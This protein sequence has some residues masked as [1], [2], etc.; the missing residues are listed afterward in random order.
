MDP[1]S[2]TLYNK[3]DLKI[4][5]LNNDHLWGAIHVHLASAMRFIQPRLLFILELHLSNYLGP[6]GGQA[7]YF[8]Y[9]CSVVQAALK[10]VH[11]HGI[12]CEKGLV[13]TIWNI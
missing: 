10:F 3:D 4:E 5:Y 2:L 12:N 13:T 11:I 8:S 9:D 7:P 1:Q 6:L